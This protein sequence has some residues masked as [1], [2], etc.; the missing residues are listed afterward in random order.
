MTTKRDFNAELTELGFSVKSQYVFPVEPIK[1]SEHMMRFIVTVYYKNVHVLTTD[2]FMGIGHV[3]NYN[4]PRSQRDVGELIYTLKTGNPAG[5]CRPHY[6]IPKPDIAGVMYAL[7]HD[8]DVMNYRTFE[9]WASE[10][11]YDTDSRKAESTFRAC[12][13]IGHKWH[14]NIPADV[15]MEIGEILS[16]Y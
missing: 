16:D 9:E 13:E 8:A 4:S 6:G 11:G 15:R 14:A 3:K 1:L 5:P 10:F 7:H 2:Y 12:L